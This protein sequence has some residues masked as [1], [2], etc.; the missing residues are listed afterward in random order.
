MSRHNRVDLLLRFFLAFREWIEFRLRHHQLLVGP[1]HGDKF[2]DEGNLKAAVHLARFIAVRM[3][4]EPAR[5]SVDQ[6]EV[7]VHVLVF[8]HRAAHD[9]LGNEDERNDVGG[10]F[11]V[12][13]E[14]GDDQA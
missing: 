10:R 5:E 8:D 14:R 7:P 3:L 12:V 13:H 9:D 2:T 6:S 11:R 4:L 1:A